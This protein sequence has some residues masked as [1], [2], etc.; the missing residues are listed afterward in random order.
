MPDTSFPPPPADKATLEEG[1]ALTPRF[2]PDGLVTAV[3]ADAADGALLMVAHMNAEALR[4]TIET[5]AAHYWSRSRARI[6]KKGESS[7][8]VQR[9]TELRVDCDQD[10]ILVK[11]RV[12]GHDATCHTGRRSCFYR[13]IESGDGGLRLVTDPEKPR[14]DPDRVYGDAK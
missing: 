2:G 13:R 3:V 4:L 12:E 9:V 1:A 6:W 10:A 14:F 5:G 7:G 8:N 11:V